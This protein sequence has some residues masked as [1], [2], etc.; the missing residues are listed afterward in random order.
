[1]SILTLYI[2][3]L[4]F[5][6]NKNILT[7]CPGCKNHADNICLKK[8]IM[9]NK[10]IKGK[11]RYADCMANKSFFDKIKHKSERDIVASQFLINW[12]L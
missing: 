2:F 10:E 9:A 12:I 4:F 6:I 5:W 7:Y 3:F 8:L 1:M 11:S